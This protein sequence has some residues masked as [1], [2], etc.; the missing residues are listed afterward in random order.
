MHTRL[1]QLPPGMQE[2]VML[3]SCGRFS[4]F[5]SCEKLRDYG[6]KKKKQQQRFQL[7]WLVEVKFEPRWVLRMTAQAMN[8]QAVLL[9]SSTH[10]EKEQFCFDLAAC[11]TC[12]IHQFR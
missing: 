9:I 2:R 5:G 1:Y 8:A 10:R 6:T 11:V 12:T 4:P 7:L 3:C